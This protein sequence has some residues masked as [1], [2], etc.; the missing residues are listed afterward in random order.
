[1]GAIRLAWC[2]AL[3]VTLRALAGTSSRGAA[4]AIAAVGA[5]ATLVVLVRARWSR[6]R[7]LALIAAALALGSAAIFSNQRLRDLVVHRRWT[8]DAQESNRQ[9]TAMLTAG[10]LLGT[11]RP[12]LGWGPGTVPL[13]YP[14]V[15]SLLDGGV[16]DVLQ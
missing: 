5:V 7:K 3:A 8:D 15:R 16:D 13:A 6:G 4:L 14:H 1:R 12:L 9:R 2:L 11:E 10:R